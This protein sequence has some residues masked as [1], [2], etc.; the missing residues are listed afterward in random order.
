[1]LAGSLV[2]AVGAYLFQLI[3]GRALGTE[4]FA[5]ISVL[6]TVFF[7]LATVVLVPLEQYITREASLG[8]RVLRH[9]PA[10]I[11]SVTAGA[12]VRRRLHSPSSPVSPCSTARGS[13]PC[14]SRC[15]WRATRCCWSARVCW[16]A[17][18]SSRTWDGSCSGS[19][20]SASSPDSLILAIVVNA[21]VLGWAMVIAP[22]AA[23][24]TRFWRFDVEPIDQ[25]R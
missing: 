13:S 10:P 22:L 2:G 19:R 16:P 21:E 11:V 3:G 20:P 15:S 12:A 7:I 23:L 18:A 24:G 4:A 25:A 9:E 5:P 17:T 8:K 1:M 6:W 14:S